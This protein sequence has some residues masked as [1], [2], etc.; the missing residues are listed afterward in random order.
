MRLLYYRKI[1]LFFKKVLYKILYN[2]LEIL[3]NIEGNVNYRILKNK[4]CTK[5]E[6][7]LF[8]LKL[9]LIKAFYRSHES[10]LKKDIKISLPLWRCFMRSFKKDIKASP[11]W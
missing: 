6:R 8:Y 2:I 3:Q 9:D 7:N 1:R 10:V 4:E 5:I 11:A